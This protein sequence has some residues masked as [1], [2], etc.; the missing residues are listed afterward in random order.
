MNP[1]N[2]T[3]DKLI[4]VKGCNGNNVLISIRF[5]KLDR[6]VKKID[7]FSL[8]HEDDLKPSNSRTFSYPLGENLSVKK[9]KKKYKELSVRK[10]N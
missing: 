8:G 7:V 6:K 9:L 4:A 1:Q 3:M 10:F 5:P 2:I